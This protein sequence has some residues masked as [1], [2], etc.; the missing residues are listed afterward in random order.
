MNKE[1]IDEL[2]HLLR[3]TSNIVQGKPVNLKTG[4]TP[5]EEVSVLYGLCRHL[6]AGGDYNALIKFSA[7]YGER[8]LLEP[9]YRAIQRQN[10]SPTRV[11]DFGSGLGWLGR[12]LAANLGLLPTLFVDK[13]PWTL[14]DVVADLETEEGRTRVFSMMKDGDLIVMSDFLHCL[15]NPKEVMEPFSRWPVAALE[16]C[17]TRVDYRDSYSTQVSRY[18]AKPVSS[19]ALQDIFP[20]RRIDAEDLDPYILLLVDRA[21]E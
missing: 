5:A 8:F 3:V 6:L 17:P 19:E 13:R 14:V 15:D 18:G 9:T 21:G 12:G 16:Y 20:S 4:L 2:Y 10:W 11:V 1:Q 7:Y